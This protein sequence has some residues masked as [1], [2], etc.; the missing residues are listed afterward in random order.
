MLSPGPGIP[1]NAGMMPQLLSEFASTKSILGICLGHQAIA[2]HFG[3]DLI[4]LSEPLRRLLQK[5]KF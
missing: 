3:T 2:E 1:K 4:N 5:L